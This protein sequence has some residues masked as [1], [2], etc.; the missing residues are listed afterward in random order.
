MGAVSLLKRPPAL[1]YVTAA[2][3][4]TAAI[5]IPSTAQPGDF[6]V[7]LDTPVSTIATPTLVVPAGWTTGMDGTLPVSPYDRLTVSGKILAAGEPGSS[8][9][10][11]TGNTS[12]RKSVMIFRPNSRPFSS[13]TGGGA[14]GARADGDLPAQTINVSGA[15]VP[16][17]AVGVAFSTG[18][19]DLSSSTMSVIAT[20]TL[21]RQLAYAILRDNS[22]S[23]Q[24]DMSDD[25]SNNVLA[26]CYFS[27]R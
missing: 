17:I 27:L 3:A 6:A 14:V 24:I 16:I 18:T 20:D 1:N 19:S 10:G 23:P 21:T 2:H 15:G 5:T 7:L 12:S 26:G 9:T 11:M 13:V 4:N 22:V 8:I 25:G